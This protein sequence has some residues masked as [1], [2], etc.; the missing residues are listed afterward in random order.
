MKVQQRYIIIWIIAPILLVVLMLASMAYGTVALP[1][2]DVLSALGLA[3]GQVTPIVK[4]IILELRLPRT[5]L[6]V[7]SGTGLALVGALLQSTT[8]NDL[9]DPFLFGLSSG[10]SAGAVWVITRTGNSLGDWTLPV[11]AFS[12]GVVSAITVII[13]FISQSYKDSGRLIISG[14]AVSFLFGAATSYLVFTGDQ[15]AASSV[16]FWS[17]GGLGLANWSNLPLALCGVLALILLISIRWRALDA[18]LAGEQI[19]HSLGVK[20]P[21]LRVEIFLC[22]ALTTST[23]VALSGVI[24]FVGLMVPHLARVFSGVRHHRLLP[25]VALLGAILLLSGD[26]LSRILSAPQELPVGIIT[27]GL[28]GFFI[29]SMLLRRNF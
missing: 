4:S 25:L 29:L 15:R 11:A 16:L 12:G 28:G 22:C 24:G 6:A 14:L 3:D 19:A 17:L 10:A 9:A 2:R 7:L 27:G 18:L 21:H 23:L 1:L 5:L 20:V 26:L 13:L 8:Q